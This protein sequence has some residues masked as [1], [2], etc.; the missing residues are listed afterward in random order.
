VYQSSQKG[1]ADS[2]MKVDEETFWD[3]YKLAF[4]FY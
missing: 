4:P 1:A 2:R 3:H